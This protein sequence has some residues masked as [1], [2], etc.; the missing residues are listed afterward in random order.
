MILLI[1]MMLTG[2][3]FAPERPEMTWGGEGHKL[4]CEI[5]WRHMTPS[6]RALAA[7]LR[8]GETGQ[9]SESC[10]WA[11][12]VRDDRPE[13]YHYHFINIPSGQSGV[14]LAR[15]CGDAAKRCVTWAIKHY[16]QILADRRQSHL[17]R[18]EALKF[19]GHF[20]GDLHQPLHAG[21]P[22]DRGGNEV[23]VSF[24]G[25]A[26]TEQRRMQLHSVWDSGILRRAN[27]VWPA[28]AEELTVGITRADV[29]AWANSDVLGWTN[30][31]YQIA[32]EFVY[33]VANGGDIAEPYYNRALQIARQRLQQGGIRLAHLLNE[34]A[35]GRALFDF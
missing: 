6:A 12:E 17:A 31:S 13:T 24:F 32:E 30:E 22:G 8:S 5:A 27:L 34:A 23:R 29:S 3:A 20:V 4:V 11:D 2:P 21:R 15:D 1:I 14:N 9:F 33:N 18:S 16:T 28:S 7:Q 25:D 35:R 19:V 10:I 26:G